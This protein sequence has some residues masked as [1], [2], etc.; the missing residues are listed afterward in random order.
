MTFHTDVSALQRTP[1]FRDVDPAKLKLLAI[2]SQ[3]VEHDAG[4]VLLVQGDLPTGVYVILEGTAD[5]CRSSAGKEVVVARVG[6][7]ELVGEMSVLTGGAYSASIRATT[8]LVALHIDKH[9]FMEILD[10]VPQITL[11]IS[12]ELCRRLELANE[13]LAMLTSR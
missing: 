2:A 5:V 4:E 11:A 12:R 8:A 3:R 10:A 6:E 9:A 13:R 1:V 7:G